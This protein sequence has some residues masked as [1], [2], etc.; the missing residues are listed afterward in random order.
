MWP[1]QAGPYWQA[2]GDGCCVPSSVALTQHSAV[3]L[4]RQDHVDAPGQAVAAGCAVSR[5]AVQIVQLVDCAVPAEHAGM[6]KSVA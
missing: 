3:P 2:A 4:M 6:A 5:L 1:L